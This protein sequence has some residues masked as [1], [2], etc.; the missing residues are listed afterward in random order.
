MNN[1]WGY[2]WATWEMQAVLCAWMTAGIYFLGSALFTNRIKRREA[3]SGRLLD[4]TLLWGGYF[5]MFSQ[6]PVLGPLLR[7]FLPNREPLEIAGVAF[8]WV[9]APLCIWARICLGRY[10]SGV[11]ALKQD[12]RLIQSGPYRLIRHPIYTGLILAAIGWCLVMPA[13]SSLLGALSLTTCFM[14]RAYRED[15]LLAAE[16]GAEFEAYRQRTGRL[17]PRVG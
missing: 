5:V 2:G 17:A 12:H 9:G 13:W 10:W 3:T 15:A 4:L 6:A 14:R 11:V 16:F 8:A 1:A 7:H